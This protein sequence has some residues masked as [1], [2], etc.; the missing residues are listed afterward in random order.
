M[1]GIK[2]ESKSSKSFIAENRFKKLAEKPSRKNFQTKNKSEQLIR[3]NPNLLIKVF[4]KISLFF[5]KL[6]WRFVWRVSIVTFLFMSTAVSYYYL[7]L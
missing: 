2:K 5:L 7:N 1:A 3:S 6:I 4:E